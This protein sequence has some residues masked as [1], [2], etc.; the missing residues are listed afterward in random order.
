MQR[1][2]NTLGGLMGV[3]FAI[4]LFSAAI[5]RPAAIGASILF[6]G[7]LI[8]ML[9]TVVGALFARGVRRVEW[10]GA[11]IFG[12]SYLTIAFGPF[13]WL[14]ND[15]LRPLILANL[16]LADALPGQLT[17]NARWEGRGASIYF[18]T[19]IAPRGVLPID[20]VAR[21]G[22]PRRDESLQ[23]LFALPHFGP[24]RRDRS[25]GRASHRTP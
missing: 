19:S 14:N 18:T 10:T 16:P 9:T 21:V 22:I 7:V 17:A 12:W 8:L 15:G 4:A 1:H 5:T 23:I 3:V 2:R 13:A 6:T 20:D 24:F 25:G 11:A